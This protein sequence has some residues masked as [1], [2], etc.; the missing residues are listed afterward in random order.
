MACLFNNL[1]LQ[2]FILIFYLAIFMGQRAKS[3]SNLLIFSKGL[4]IKLLTISHL[5]VI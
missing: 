1:L 5:K 4:G 2:P 3:Q